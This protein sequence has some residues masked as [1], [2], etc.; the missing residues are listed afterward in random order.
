M[1]FN[2]LIGCIK[3]EANQNTINRTAV[4][5]VIKKGNEILLVSNNK[6]DTKFPGGGVECNEDLE[7]ALKREVREETGYTVSSIGDKIGTVIERRIDLFDNDT[8]FEMKSHYYLCNV[9]E[10]FQKQSLDAYEQEMEFIP[11][12]ITIDEAIKRNQIAA[13]DKN[14]WVDRELYVLNQLNDYY[15]E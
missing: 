9:T 8:V 4:R 7:E 14:L 12:W 5:A 2:H 13:K 15:C 10:D 1:R 11:K 6:G 3:I